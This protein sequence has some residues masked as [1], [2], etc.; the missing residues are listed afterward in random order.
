MSD[1]RFFPWVHRNQVREKYPDR[2]NRP[3]NNRP[4]KS[5][6]PPERWFWQCE[7]NTRIATSAD[8]SVVGESQ[9]V[10][11][12]LS[13]GVQNNNGGEKLWQIRDRT[14]VPALLA[15][16]QAGAEVTT[17]PISDGDSHHP[18]SLT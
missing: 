7:Y 16:R 4:R 13:S 3:G 17:P 15:I 14:T 2:P 18:A 5:W 8:S 10:A 12:S 1:G 11:R 6:R 9:S